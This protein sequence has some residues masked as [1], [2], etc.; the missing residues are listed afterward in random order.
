MLNHLEI[1]ET[2]CHQQARAK[3]AL[4][5]PNAS[6]SQLVTLNSLRDCKKKWT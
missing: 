4:F 1:S 6:K 5:I 3:T 2:C